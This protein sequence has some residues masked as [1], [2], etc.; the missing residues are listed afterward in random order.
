MKLVGGGNAVEVVLAA[1][2]QK[3]PQKPEARSAT[4]RHCRGEAYGEALHLDS[5][6]N[7]SP[8]KSQPQ[9]SP[10]NMYAAA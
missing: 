5:A 8:H 4:T 7:Q 1:A 9:T 2:A 3:V 6:P 10:S